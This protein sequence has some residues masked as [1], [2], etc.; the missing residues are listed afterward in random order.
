MVKSQL[1]F[2]LF[3]LLPV[4]APVPSL[5]GLSCFLYGIMFAIIK[6]QAHTGGFP[7]TRVGARGKY[8]TLITGFGKRSDAHSGRFRIYI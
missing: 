1:L 2:G 8:A 5:P 4:S 6:K 7:V 3:F